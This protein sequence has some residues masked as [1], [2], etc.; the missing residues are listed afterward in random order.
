MSSDG[1]SVLW[2]FRTPIRGQSHAED[3]AR[4]QE[5]KKQQL[6]TRTGEVWWPRTRRMW[7]NF[8]LGFPAPIT[9]EEVITKKH[10]LSIFNTWVI[11]DIFKASRNIREKHYALLSPKLDFC[12]KIVAC[13]EKK[14]SFKARH[15][16]KFISSL[17]HLHQDTS[18]VLIKEQ[19]CDDQTQVQV[20]L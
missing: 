10:D 6:N 7:C 4:R 8:Q 11:I 2:I 15:H 13:P 14:T 5:F 12:H 20:L 18:W 3:T 1:H 9:G 16:R 19:G 17:F